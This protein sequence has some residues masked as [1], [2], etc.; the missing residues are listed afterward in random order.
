[1]YKEQVHKPQE[2][3]ETPPPSITTTTTTTISSLPHLR[4]RSV[5]T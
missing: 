5:N 3:K 4:L 1:M 2:N